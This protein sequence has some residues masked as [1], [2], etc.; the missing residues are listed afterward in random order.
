MGKKQNWISFFKSGYFLKHLAILAGIIIVFFMV[1]SFG[2][3]TFTNHGEAIDMPNLDG[4]FIET[5]N[6]IVKKHKF[7]LEKADSVFIVGKP[8]GLIINQNPKPGSKVKRGRTI[9]LTVTKDKADEIPSSRLPVL[10]GKSY[11]RKSRELK[12]GFEIF[13]RV[14]EEQYDAGPE[15]YIL[16]VIYEGDTI[17]SSEIR[18]LDVM[19]EKGGQLDMV[20][21]KSTG[22]RLE[23]PNMVCK[24]YSEA[25]FLARTL[26]INLDAELDPDVMDRYDAFI[27]RQTPT[28]SP[29]SMI[30]MGDTI[31]VFL[32]ED[33][34]LHCM[35][36]DSSFDQE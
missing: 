23:L 36:V 18:K 26:N 4:E 24:T 34:P 2:L 20:V 11:D 22:G 12:N 3:K 16:A 29:E 15:N 32:G 7:K 6:D 25:V 9:Y 27:Y 8:G 21:S 19:I 35:E 17:V 1:V 31:K 13:T 30:L 5:A 33:R 14:V 10:Y 28:F